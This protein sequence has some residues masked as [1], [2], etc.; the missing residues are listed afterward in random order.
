MHFNLFRVSAVQV[1]GIRVPSS[2][3]NSDIR[4]SDPHP[5]GQRKKDN[6]SWSQASVRSSVVRISNTWE[7]RVLSIMIHSGTETARTLAPSS[8]RP[9]VQIPRTL[10]HQTQELVPQSPPP[11]DPG[12]QTPRPLLPKTNTGPDLCE[13]CCLYQSVFTPCIHHLLFRL[14]ACM[15]KKRKESSAGGPWGVL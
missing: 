6:F 8:L 13:L 2:F 7:G 15:E 3:R 10:F 12:A 9:E 11:S 4:N 5:R 14:A 1:P